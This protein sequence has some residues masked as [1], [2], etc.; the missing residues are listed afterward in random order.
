MKKRLAFG[1]AVVAITFLAVKAF[2][3]STPKGQAPLRNL[4]LDNFH[5]FESAFN[6]SNDSVRLIV[7]LSP[8]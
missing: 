8:T 4:T 6:G 2:Q 3:H 1:L 5:D 7:L